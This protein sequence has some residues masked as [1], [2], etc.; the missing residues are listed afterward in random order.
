MDL[1]LPRR[2]RQWSLL[3]GAVL[4][5]AYYRQ[6]SRTEPSTDEGSVITERHMTAFLVG[7]R[8]DSGRVEAIE[9]EISQMITG[10]DPSRLLGLEDAGTGSLFL[11]RS[12]VDP[13]LLW[14]VE[15]PRAVVDEWAD[16]E[17]RVADAFPITHDGLESVD[18]TAE[19]GLLVHAVNPDRPR[20]IGADRLVQA[21]IV[22]GPDETT[23]TTVDV[24]LVRMRLKPGTPERLADWFAGLTRQVIDGERTLDRVQSWSA[25]MI[26]LERMYTESI[27]LERGERYTL[28][29]YMEAAEMR[30]VYDAYYDTWNPVARASE[31]LL[32]RLLENPDRILDYPP[33]TEIRLLAHAIDPERPRRVQECLER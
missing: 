24:E 12:G 15:L 6:R 28:Y 16:P 3:L 13:E 7:R 22:E 26:D 31:L 18:G 32:G 27:V 8:L 19:R 14:Y 21:P 11:D 30:R 29:Q 9:T 10:W 17:T 25:E 5:G 1:R 4:A 20:T 23:R 2:W 33:E